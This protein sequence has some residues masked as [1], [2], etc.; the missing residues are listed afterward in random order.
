MHNMS[1]LASLV[2][3]QG[4]R[5]SM[6]RC[7]VCAG[8][9]RRFAGKIGSALVRVRAKASASGWGGHRTRQANRGAESSNA[10]A[11]TAD[12]LR[13][14]RPSRATACRSPTPC[15]ARVLAATQLRQ[16]C[17]CLWRKIRLRACEGV[18]NYSA[19]HTLMVVTGG[20]GI[21]WPRGYLRI[22]RQVAR[23]SCRADRPVELQGGSPGRIAGQ[24]AR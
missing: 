14:L 24:V 1:F 3:A 5:E 19:H 17:S 2:A 10:H 13:H 4:S 15:C 21:H 12:S 18:S 7:S 11:S 22:E 9:P 23:W 6:P 16:L 8:P 20:S